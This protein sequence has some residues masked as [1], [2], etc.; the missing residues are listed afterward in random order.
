MKKTILFLVILVVILGGFSFWQGYKTGE[1]EP[2]VVTV[3]SF[4]ECADA[5]YPVM[6]SYPR[7]CE[8][9]DGR[10][11]TE[12]IGDEFEKS[13]LIVV[14]NPR[15]NSVVMSPLKV[16]G[17]ARGYWFFEADFPL[18]ML[19]SEGNVLGVGIATAKGEW[20]TDNFVDFEALLEFDNL[21]SG[22]G[23]LILEK[24]NPSGLPEN[25][26]Q[27]RIPVKFTA[28]SGLANPASVYCEGQGGTIEGR[29]VEG[30]AKGFCLF[31][32][33]SECGQWDFFRGDCKKGEMFC[34]DL[35]GDSVCQE[36]VCLA[37]G[38]P[39]VETKESCSK[40]CD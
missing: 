18:K 9:P 12:D 34:K 14:D 6:E 40:D 26:D 37:L 13:D 11:F 25:D 24:D 17:R 2:P 3:N 29:I 35:C 10:V 22:K 16:E 5:G 15:P 20:M 31:E 36:I 8:A 23:D 21:G 7:Q 4:D 38:C 1:K 19:D 27:L 32:D 39:C 30:G 33:G 28:S